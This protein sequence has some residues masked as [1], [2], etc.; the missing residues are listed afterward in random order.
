MDYVKLITEALVEKKWDDI[1]RYATE[2]KNKETGELFIGV[3]KGYVNIFYGYDNLLDLNLKDAN[4][5][6]FYAGT[7]PEL[8]K[9]IKAK[10]ISLDI[11]KDECVVL[12]TSKATVVSKLISLNYPVTYFTVT[13]KRVCVKGTEKVENICTIKN[14][15]TGESIKF[16]LDINNTKALAGFIRDNRINDIFDDEL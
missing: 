15:N 1:A 2:A 3:R 11:I 12:F 14:K 13:N 9:L 10:Q 7:Q 16:I 8:F 5:K 6:T 4:I